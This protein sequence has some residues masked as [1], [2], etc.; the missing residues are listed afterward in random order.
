[1]ATDRVTSAPR[2][3]TTTLTGEGSL[4]RFLV[5]EVMR[6]EF[7]STPCSHLDFTLSVVIVVVVVF[8]AVEITRF[9]AFMHCVWQ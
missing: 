5:R 9:Y 3:G 1:M 2:R 4:L 8:V 6:V 7:Q